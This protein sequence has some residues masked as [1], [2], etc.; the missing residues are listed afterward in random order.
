LLL[1]SGTFRALPLSTGVPGQPMPMTRRQEDR[2]QL[3]ASRSHSALE[4]PAGSGAGSVQV[5][6]KV[7]P[8]SDRL[9]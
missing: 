6:D 7:T 4:F 9:N 3:V 8:G 1:M 5:Q 2:A